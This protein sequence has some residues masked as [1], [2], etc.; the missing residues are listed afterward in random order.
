MSMD[1]SVNPEVANVTKNL[2]NEKNHDF[3]ANFTVRTIKDI[4]TAIA[5]MDL[6]IPAYTGDV[7]YQKQVLKTTVDLIKVAKGVEANFMTKALMEKLRDSIDFDLKFPFKKVSLVSV[8]NHSDHKVFSL[9][10][11]KVYKLTNFSVSDRFIPFYIG[12]Q[13]SLLTLRFVGK[14]G[15]LKG[16]TFIGGFRIYC[17]QSSHTD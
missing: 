9:K 13:K 12:G 2:V 16:S 8:S 10:Q 3:R 17:V 11:D 5:Y 15:G 14:V 7:S 1:L 6:K 4:F